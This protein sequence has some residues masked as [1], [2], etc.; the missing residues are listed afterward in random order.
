[1]PT[2]VTL[3]SHA[4]AKSTVRF[5][6]KRATIQYARIGHVRMKTADLAENAAIAF[7]FLVGL[8]KEG[9]ENVSVVVM[10]SSMGPPITLYSR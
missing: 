1:M 7:A 4:Q 8:L 2:R 10:K 6:L 9:M 5:Q 3:N